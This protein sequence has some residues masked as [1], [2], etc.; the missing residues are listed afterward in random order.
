MGTA[1]DDGSAMF[2]HANVNPIAT[3]TFAVGW[4]AE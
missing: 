1:R 2:E 4:F 3:F